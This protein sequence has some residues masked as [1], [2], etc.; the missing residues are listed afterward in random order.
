MQQTDPLQ[1]LAHPL[2]VRICGLIAA[3]TGCASL[4]GWLL[5]TAQLTRLGQELVPMAPVSAVLFISYGAALLWDC[6]ANPGRRTV[7]WSRGVFGSGALLSALLLTCSL[8]GI[9]FDQ[10]FLGVVAAGAET[11]SSFGHMA[12]LTAGSFLA[13]SLLFLSLCCTRP[14]AGFRVKSA[15]WV[16]VALTAAHA[17]LIMAYLFGP[18]AS[19]GGS[20]IAPAA[21][22][23]LAFVA[24]GVALVKLWHARAW[25]HLATARPEEERTS[26]RLL[27]VI[28]LLLA[29]GVISTVYFYSQDHQRQFLADA[30]QQLSAIADLKAGE[31]R[32]W[33]EERLGDAGIFH[34]NLAFAS[35]VK[36]WFQHPGEPGAR[37]EIETWL[38]HVK[39]DR[40][41]NRIFLLDALGNTRLSLPESAVEPIS[42]YVRQKALG[43]LQTDS[44]NFA[45]FYRQDTS[46]KIYLAILV[47][48][49]DPAWGGRPLGVLVMRIDS[50]K[51]LYPFIKRWPNV[52][53]SAETLL[54]R[55]DGNKA[56][57]LNALR[58]GNGAALR[59]STPLAGNY[60]PSAMAVSG[61]E[62]VVRGVDYRGVPVLAAL[63]GVPGSPWFLVVQIAIE[64]VYA[65]M[66]QRQWMTVLLVSTVL[67]ST[68][69]SVAFLW[70][71]Q[72]SRFYRD[73]H[74]AAQQRSELEQRLGWI[75]ACA[76]GAIFQFQLR[77]DGS[78]CFP[79]ASRGL[80]ALYGVTPESVS[81]DAAPFFA[82]IAPG[83][84]GRVAETLRES[85][86]TLSPWRNE[87]RVPQPGGGEIWL[88]G[89]ATPEQ[90]PDGSV[91]FY[92]FISD[93]TQ[94]KEKERAI[95][96]K[97][98]E[99]ERFTYT[100][101][102]DLKSPLVTIKTFL[103]YLVE[104]LK[105]PG[106]PDIAQDLG[107]MHSAADK[108]S[109]LLAELL[110]LSRVGRINN[111]PVE[112]FFGA[113]A[114][115]A[116][117]LNAG[118]LSKRGVAVEISQA[119]LTL[120]G[121]RT[122]LV[123]IWQNL[124]ENA[125]KF[126]GD[127][128][129]PRIEIGFRDEGGEQ[130]FFVRDNGKGIDPR[131][132]EKIFGLFDKLEAASE[133]T[134]LGLALVKRIVELYQ[135]RIWVESSG[136]GAGT[137]FHFT[138]PAA[139]KNETTQGEQQ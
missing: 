48:I 95:E 130:Q 74:Q 98:S 30:E 18:P 14:G 79:Y 43:A 4:A 86:R 34:Q 55:R 89:M 102:H 129:K 61:R 21:N 29:T 63:R 72:Y 122:R 60:H 133:G 37:R 23:S 105:T 80:L 47:P 51:Y 11:T 70:R 115:E 138:L 62:G 75:A 53:G 68:G 10:E 5:G 26:A 94:A 114:R 91:Q 84:A 69:I 52:S 44:V 85:A 109:Q 24:L 88:E 7:L 93:C 35:L 92:G 108:M 132:H 25:P 112:V 15:W 97:N 41:Y 33:R 6:Q 110:E 134:G 32:L 59:L 124:V 113:L 54:V 19:W 31:L 139:I 106:N 128:P 82:A 116:A 96:E 20:V 78:S 66:R 119:S 2:L 123:E 56:L 118:S 77:P 90:N 50:E 83:D 13:F 135:G 3:A 131:Y 65:P 64:E 136:K 42:S 81:R 1:Q 27:F 67:L 103:G 12:P 28:F 104:D 120:F 22:T 46:G 127:Q 137:T 117:Q 111:A 99:L 125:G 8:Q 58:H 76:P 36:R 40:N 49:F 107:F 121:D 9:Y 38:A 100:V 87:H 73:Q 39:T 17:A 101:S 71:Q 57:F 126:M 16:A 45:D